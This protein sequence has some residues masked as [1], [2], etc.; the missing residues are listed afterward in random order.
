[1]I[2]S[3]GEA[4]KRLAAEDSPDVSMQ[5][6]DGLRKE[7][8]AVM[9]LVANMIGLDRFRDKMIDFTKK[10]PRYRDLKMRW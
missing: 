9:G 7:M 10:L 6:Q 3:L 2:N 1:M 4:I 8:V 5:V